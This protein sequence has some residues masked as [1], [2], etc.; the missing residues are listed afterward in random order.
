MRVFLGGTCNESTWRPELIA[1]LEIEYFD[2]VVEDWTPACQ[3]REIQERES[4]DWVLYVITP[5]ITW[6]YSIA[7]VVD[8][9]NKWPARTLFAVIGEFDEGLRRSL[10]AVE[11]LVASNGAHVFNSLNDVASYLN[12]EVQNDLEIL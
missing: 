12:A 9:S 7:E 5:E 8:D 6:V 3:A 1:L 10:A 11:K 2:P 4:C